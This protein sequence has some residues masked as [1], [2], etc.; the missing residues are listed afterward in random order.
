MSGHVEKRDCSGFVIDLVPK[1]H[2]RR[3]HSEA[4]AELVKRD[5]VGDFTPI[6][7]SN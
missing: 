6:P 7:D 3:K 4:K 5:G 2:R 1:R